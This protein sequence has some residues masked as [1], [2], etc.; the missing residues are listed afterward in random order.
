MLAAGAPST[1]EKATASTASAGAATRAAEASA[2]KSARSLP[3]GA[4]VRR[5]KAWREL[6]GRRIELPGGDR[7]H[8][9]VEH[10]AIEVRRVGPSGDR[11]RV[12]LGVL[13]REAGRQEPRDILSFWR[14][15]LRGT[16]TI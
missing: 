7:L 3:A 15:C 13:G 16:G 1:E 9:I 6:P 14:L 4:A 5:P 11:D 12:G 10:A 2:A 8:P